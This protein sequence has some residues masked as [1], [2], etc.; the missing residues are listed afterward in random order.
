[1][2]KTNKGHMLL[3]TRDYELNVIVVTVNDGCK[4]TGWKNELEMQLGPI[5]PISLNGDAEFVIV[6]VLAVNRF[7]I[8]FLVSIL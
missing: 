8:I 1:M 2:C 4:K 7:I 3:K 5:M 6:F